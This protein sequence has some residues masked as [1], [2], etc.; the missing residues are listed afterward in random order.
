MTDEIRKQISLFL[1][2]SDWRILRLEA[3]RRRLP[4]T[5]LCRQWMRPHMDKLRRQRAARWEL[6]S[7]DAG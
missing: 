2:V 3:A 5:E 7:P 6:E 1:P 4:I